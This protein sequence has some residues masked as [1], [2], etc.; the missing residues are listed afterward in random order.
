MP[1]SQI[2]SDSIQ[3]GAV[4]PVDLSSVAQYTGFKNRLINGA[5]A[6]SQRGTT[7]SGVGLSAQTYTLDRWAVICTGAGIGISQVAGISGYQYALQMTGAASNTQAYLSQRIE[8]SNIYD[9]AGSAVTLSAVIQAS[10]AQ[11]VIWAAYYPTAKDNY[12][13]FTSIATGTF[14]VTTSAQSFSTQISLPSGAQN[15]LWILFYPQNAGAFTSGTLTITGVQ[16]EKGVTATSFDYRPYGTELSLCQRYFEM[17]YDIGVTPGTAPNTAGAISTLPTAYGQYFPITFK[18]TKRVAPTTV[19]YY[20]PFNGVANNFSINQSSNGALSGTVS[21]G[22][23]GMV[24]YSAP[25]SGNVVCY[26]H[27]T[28]SSEL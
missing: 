27:Y 1:L 11:S 19:N 4:A 21:T 6:I 17:S 12:T 3:D 15:G 24:P 13:S 10:T 23:S 28:A 26:L 18:V 16:L 22:M 25:S 14:S 2:V 8:S 9:L 20:S 5:M 7:F